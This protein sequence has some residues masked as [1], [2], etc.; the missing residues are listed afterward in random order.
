LIIN[1][2]GKSVDED[3]SIHVRVG[4]SHH[5]ITISEVISLY[6][7]DIFFFLSNDKFALSFNLQKYC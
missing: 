2:L 7:S 1:V 6:S 4:L 5:A 3:A